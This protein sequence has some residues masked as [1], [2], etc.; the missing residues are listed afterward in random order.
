[1]RWSRHPAVVLSAAWLAVVL[2][3]GT[4]TSVVVSRAGE[5]VGQA[6]AAGSVARPPVEPASRTSPAPSPA[7]TGP[8]A[9]AASPGGESTA[10]PTGRSESPAETPAGST[11]DATTPGP[12]WRTA[13]FS[14]AG[15]TVV[16]SC[17]AASIRLDSVTVRDGWAFDQESEDGGA[18]VV[19]R[20]DGGERVEVILAC[21]DGVPV[22][23]TD[24]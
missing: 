2:A 16:A 8:S 7:G 20:H 17:R 14:V 18:E 11:P 6:S 3:V 24:R 23:R 12:V 10:D 13:S 4:I 5:G 21:Q 19:F 22:Q 9:A 1:V 15:G